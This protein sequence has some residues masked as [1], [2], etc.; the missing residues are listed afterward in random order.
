ME[1]AVEQ[2]PLESFLFVS[3]ILFSTGVYGV[4]S[5]RN[6]VQIIMSVELMLNAVAVNFVAF[7]AYTD[8]ELFRGLIFAVFVII[9]AAAE[10][11]LALG[12]ILRVFRTRATANVD[13]VSRS[14]GNHGTGLAPAGDPRRSLHRSR[15]SKFLKIPLPREGDFIGVGASIAAFIIMLMVALR[16]LRPAA[17]CRCRA[18]QQQRRLRLDQRSRSIDFVLRVGFHVDQITSS[19]SSCVTFIALMVN[20]YSL[21]YMHGE[22]RYGWFFAVALA[23]RRLDARRWCSPTTCCC[24]TSPGSCVGVCSFL[25][26]GFY[27]E[28]RS[29][30]EAAKKAFITTRFGDVGLLIGIILLWRADRHLQHPGRSSRWRETGAVRQVATSRSST[31]FLF[32]G[33]CGKSAQFP[34]PRLAAGRDG[35]PDAG[36]RADP[37]RDDG[38]RRRLPRRAHAAAVRGRATACPSRHGRSASITTL[39]AAF[40]GL[41]ADRHQARRRLLHAQQPR[42]DVRRARLGGAASARRCSTCSSHAFFK[43]LLFLCCGSVIHATDEQEVDKLG[44]LWKQDAD[45]RRR[46]SSSARMAMAGLVPFSGFWAKD[47]ILVDAATSTARI[48]PLVLILR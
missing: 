12:I 18:G 36:L 46:R 37:R 41:V 34:L 23:L 48:I 25:L 20:I 32:A 30:A 2:I 43:A 21:G 42:A 28:R 27:Y 35:G 9:I 3:A 24:S 38:R 11:G 5:R 26:I 17:G 15:S 39:L 14:N 10:V 29:A 4:L 47:E 16:P 8:P 19:C 6:A 1:T 31:L 44:G 13:E 7:A 40:M 45:H 33:A 22:P